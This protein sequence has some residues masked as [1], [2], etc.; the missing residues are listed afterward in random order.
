MKFLVT[1][2]C[3]SLLFK[4]IESNCN[5][6]NNG[7][8]LTVIVSFQSLHELS[9]W[10]FKNQLAPVYEELSKC[11]KWHFIPCS[12]TEIVDQVKNCDKDDL[13]E[14]QLDAMHACAAHIYEDSEYQLGH[15]FICMMTSEEQFCKG[16]QCANSA[17]LDWQKI[18]KCNP[19]QQAAKF[20]VNRYNQLNALHVIH[21]PGVFFNWKYDVKL[22]EHI[23]K[24][25][26]EHVCIRLQEMGKSCAACP[27]SPPSGQNGR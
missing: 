20:C 7:Q 16:E 25:F 19:S 15:F 17:G 21:V 24:N 1:I 5:N 18:K 4:T 13:Q 10:F 23:F 11:V 2:F 8:D 14:C 3:A 6:D 9:I 22:D 27:S 12:T 26:K